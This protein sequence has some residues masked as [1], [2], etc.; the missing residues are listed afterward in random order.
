MIVAPRPPSTSRR[1]AGSFRDPSGYVFRRGER[2]FRAIDGR[3]HQVLNDLARDGTLDRLVSEGWIVPTQLIEAPDV[4]AQLAAENPGYAHFLEHQRV[5]PITY[6]Y[7]W[8]VSM[9]AGAAVH[10]LQ[11]QL[12]LLE[13]GCSLKDASAYN[14][15]FVAG[16]PT[17]I[18]LASIERPR[19][20]DLWYALDQFNRMFTFPLLLCRHAGW[21]LRSYFL[22]RPGGRCVEEVVRAAGRFGRWRPGFLLDATLPHLMARL[23][24][25]GNRA[26]EPQPVTASQGDDRPQQW[27]LLRLR[28][29]VRRLAAGYRPGGTWT[30]Y[31]A[32]CGYDPIAERAKKDLVR[33]FLA[34]GRPGSV[35][36]LGCNTGDYSF[37]AAA[38][39]A[40]VIAA[41]KDH[42]AIE[43]LYRRLR[44]SRAPIAPVVVDLM[45]PSPGLGFRNREHP[46]FLERAGG[47]CVL[48]LALVHHLIVSG[49]LSPEAI[50]D[51]LFDLS[52]RD[53][54]VEYVPP[55]DPMF[56]RLLAGR[57]ERF[58]ELTLPKFRETFQ[59][60]FHLLRE[61]DIPNSQR[62]LLFFRKRT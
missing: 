36:D 25:G 10:T 18:D 38:C 35:L 30:K 26:S 5:R 22:G 57:T 42:D 56:R 40:R 61:A 37:L 13:V 54:V 29:K 45:S 9:L 14:V 11:M 4:R 15:Q 1:V 6:P 55:D 16:R 48:A 39:G 46:S 50:R 47:E 27:N 19:R 59:R 8:S 52:E 49:N 31:T 3:C 7:E 60:R 34:A 24:Q 20:R 44:K 17:W 43:L 2:V 33:E 41:D 51:Q 21:D 58:D 32:K 62:T 12:R 28:R 23:A 53:L